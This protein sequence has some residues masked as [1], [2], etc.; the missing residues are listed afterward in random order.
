VKH[1]RNWLQEN[2]HDPYPDAETK[3]RLALQCGISEKQVNTW[4]TNTRA[5]KLAMP[6]D[7]SYSSSDDEGIYD[8][9]ISSRADT[10]VYS[11]NRPYSFGSSIKTSMSAMDHPVPDTATLSPQTSRRGKK[12]DY[13]R[14]NNAPPNEESPIP[15]TSATPS[16]HPDG[17]EQTTWQCTFC[18]QHLV[19]KSWRRHEETQHRPKRQWTCLATGPRLIINSRSGLYTMCAFCSAKNPDEN[20]FLRSHRILECSKKSEAERTFGRPDHLRQHVKNFHKCSL[21][22]QIRDKWRRDEPGKNFNE[23]WRCGFCGDEL[24]TWD[25]RETHIANHFKAGATMASWTDYTQVTSESSKDKQSVAVPLLGQS[26]EYQH[27]GQQQP[28][29]T[30]H[31]LGSFPDMN[32]YTTTTAGPSSSQLILDTNFDLYADPFQVEYDFSDLSA[33][34]E[35]DMMFPSLVDTMNS[36]VDDFSQSLDQFTYTDI[37]KHGNIIDSWNGQQM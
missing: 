5:R 26:I 15:Q 33:T 13:R 10:P 3:C 14:L 23:G 9:G 22:D 36:S 18:R 16:P 24:K 19:Q 11:N 21:S 29:N 6:T 31:A 28:E 8:S 1:L 17:T 12:K 27:P 30:P 20:H 4:F 32:A 2:H 35:L 25:I 7:R 37:D 34:N